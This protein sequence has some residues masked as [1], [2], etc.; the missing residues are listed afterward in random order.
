M[1]VPISLEASGIFKI[2]V[3]QLKLNYSKVNEYG[4]KLNLKGQLANKKLSK[5][6]VLCQSEP[7]VVD[8]L[9]KLKAKEV[10]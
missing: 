5:Q 7:I 10:I 6:K 4:K 1:I 9:Y 3:E 2:A 8:K